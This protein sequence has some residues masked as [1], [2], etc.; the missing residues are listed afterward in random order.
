MKRFIA[1]LLLMAIFLTACGV[2]PEATNPSTPE[3]SSTDPIQQPTNPTDPEPTDPEPTDPEPTDPEPTDPE[4]TDPEPTDPEPTDPVPPPEPVITQ[5]TMTFT[6]DC[7]FG[8]NQIAAYNNSFDQYADEKGL[9]YFLSDVKHIFENDD[10]TIVNLEGS[11]TTSTDIQPK[12]W[13]HKGDPRYVQI[14]TDNSVEVAGMGNNHRVDYGI[15]GCEE[16]VQVLTNAGV[17]WCY[18][19]N[20]LIHEVKGVKVGFVSV[21]EVY[22]GTTVETWLTEGY[23]YL[24][25]SGCTIV[26]ALVHWGEAHTTV[27]EDY[28]VEL[29]HKLIDMGYDLVVGNHAHVLQAMEL[30]KGRMICYSLGN[31]CYGG[32]KNP[33]DKDCGIFQQTFT[34]VDGEL[35]LDTDIQ[36][37]PCSISSVSNKNDYHPVVL[38]GAERDR[39]IEKMNGYSQQF[40]FALTEDGKCPEET[41]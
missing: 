21:N 11:L 35:V 20:Y 31:F 34:L 9:D 14:L 6:G 39:V 36:F 41:E 16:T 1:V 37:T 8:R 33:T 12:N 26:I 5:I 38:E 24:R 17:G 29:G 22:D 32:S 13:N 7:T 40:G 4:P 3:T 18:D 25:Q 2:D 27:P 19:D 23:E 15:S 30:Y 28:Q 10:I